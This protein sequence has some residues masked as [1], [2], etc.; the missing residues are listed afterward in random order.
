MTAFTCR[1]VLSK[2]QFKTTYMMT[3]GYTIC[4]V[5]CLKTT[6]IPLPRFERTITG[7]AALVTLLSENEKKNIQNTK[8]KNK[9][10]KH[11]KL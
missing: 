8:Y 2:I 3:S 9:V 1:I 7:M 5:Y 6:N 11:R 10:Q 4:L